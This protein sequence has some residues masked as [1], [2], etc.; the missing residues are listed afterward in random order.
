MFDGLRGI[1]IVSPSTSGLPARI[2]AIESTL[3]PKTHD[4]QGTGLRLL[5]L[6]NHFRLVATIN[7][8]IPSAD[9]GG[10]RGLSELLIL[11]EIMHRIQ[12]Q[13]G[14]ET[15]PLPCEYFDLICGTSTGG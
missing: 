2:M 13:Q 4:P 3:P 9:G 15:M 10:I 12:R 1:Q 8:L 11:K 6:G 14:R 7:I 5:S